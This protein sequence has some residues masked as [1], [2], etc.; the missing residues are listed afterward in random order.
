MIVEDID[1]LK[2]G[3]HFRVGSSCKL[4]VGRNKEDNE[5][6]KA[7]DNPKYIK[8][9][10]PITGPVS[11]V[12]VNATKK[13]LLLSVKIMLTYAKSDPTQSYLVNVGKKKILAK[14]FESKKMAQKYLLQNL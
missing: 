14:P 13:E 3:R 7:I 10:L 1:V 6:I 4:I 8:V 9:F 5:K 2:V 11:L 12:S